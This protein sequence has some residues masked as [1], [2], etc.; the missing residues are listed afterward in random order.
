MFGASRYKVHKKNNFEYLYISANDES[1]QNVIMLHGMFGGLSNYDP[2]IEHAEG[3]N[4]IVPSIPLYDFKARKLSIQKLSGWLHK[5][6]KEL[7][8]ENPILL[9]NSMGGHLALDYALQ[10]P[11]MVS[12]LVLTGSSGIQEKDFGSSFPRRKDREYIRKQ[13]ALTFYE[14]LID[15]E[16]MDEIM[17]VV[18]S[19][20]K[21]LN[22]LAIARDTHEYN[23][24]EF[25]ADIPHATLLVW[26][27]HDEITPPEVGRTFFDK[28]PNAQLRW[29]DKCGHA[30]MMEH[31][32]TFALLLNEFLIELPKTNHSKYNTYSL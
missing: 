9:G 30:P 1:A 31:P 29:I 23:M 14:D 17:E 8:I 4:I 24:E 32:K 3:C 2:L 18:T 6:T 25:L 27:R 12:A 26:G 13:A 20:S 16:I 5:F 7:H 10:Y 11:D 22:M 28:L 19:P 21:L 15:D